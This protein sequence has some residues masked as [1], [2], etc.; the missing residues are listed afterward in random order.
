LFYPTEIEIA[1]AQDTL[2]HIRVNGYA[3]PKNGYF[4][5][6]PRQTAPQ[7]GFKAYDYD[8]DGILDAGVIAMTY[9]D[10]SYSMGTELKSKYVIGPINLDSMRAKTRFHQKER[11]PDGDSVH[12]TRLIN[13]TQLLHPEPFAIRV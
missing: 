3:R 13:M 7:M 1:T 8:E 2:P 10:N 4:W 9:L 6:A 5:I 11:H 12:D